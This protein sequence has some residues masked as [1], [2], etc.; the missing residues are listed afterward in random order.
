MET[1][2]FIL[3]AVLVI[4][5]VLIAKLSLDAWTRTNEQQTR[6]FIACTEKGG[7]WVAGN[8]VN[9]PIIVEKLEKQ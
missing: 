9:P 5:F 2:S 4:A 7:S 3:G 8:C 6:Q 1:R